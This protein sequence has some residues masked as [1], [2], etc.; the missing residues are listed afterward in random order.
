MKS[1]AELPITVLNGSPGYI[2]LLD[3]DG[4]VQVPS[5][6]DGRMA[7]VEQLQKVLILT[8]STNKLLNWQNRDNVLK[9]WMK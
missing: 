9:A 4:L 3:G 6:M 2:N 1:G 5:P 7:M 8:K